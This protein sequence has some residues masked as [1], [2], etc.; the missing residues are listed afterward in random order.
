MYNSQD[1][2]NFSL[3]RNL[4]EFPP[5]IKMN[6]PPL[7]DW[8]ARREKETTDLGYAHVL[9]ERLME[10]I[11]EFEKT[12]KDDEEIAAHLASFGQNILIQIESVGYHN[13]FFI[14]FQGLNLKDGHRVQLVQHTT[15]LNVLFTSYKLS[16]EENRPA[17]RI[18][19]CPEEKGR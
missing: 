9:Y 15:Q 5:P 11:R 12:L 1:S 17:R 8:E 14:V 18:G 2:L 3:P 4:P 6:E 19:F 10:Q 16:P 7:I 13:P